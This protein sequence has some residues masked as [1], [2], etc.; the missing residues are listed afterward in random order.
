MKMHMVGMSLLFVAIA[1][2]ASHAQT[3]LPRRPLRPLAGGRQQR[4]APDPTQQQ[5]MQLQRQI[6]EG[7]WRAA[8]QRI[9]FSDDQMLRLEQTSQRFDQRRRL[10]GQEEKGLRVTLQRE[11][12]ADSSANQATI[13]SSLERLT[14]LQHQRIDLQ[15]DEQKEFAQFMTPLQRARFLALQDQI[16]KRVADIARGRPDSAGGPAM[17]P[18]AP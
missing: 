8:K 2:S 15:A 10:L 5:R 3:G 4:L 6:R 17:T 11:T 7:F 9:G 14:A 1:S 16:R 13:A 18:N 12:L